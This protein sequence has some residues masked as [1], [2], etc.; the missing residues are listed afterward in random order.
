[1]GYESLVGIKYNHLVLKTV[2][3]IIFYSFF[4]DFGNIQTMIE[5]RKTRFKINLQK[6][7]KHLNFIDVE[8][9]NPENCN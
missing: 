4:V 1:M 7:F 5:S 9:R 8:K 3:F 2:F 6:R